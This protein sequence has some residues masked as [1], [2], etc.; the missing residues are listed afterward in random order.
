[1]NPSVGNIQDYKQEF[2]QQNKREITYQKM[3]NHGEG[4]I[5]GIPLYNLTLLP[6][7]PSL[8]SIFFPNPFPLYLV[9]KSNYISI[10]LPELKLYKGRE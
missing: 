8:K 5:G 10:K 6:F 9:S 7:S 3:L 4:L 2:E 1:M